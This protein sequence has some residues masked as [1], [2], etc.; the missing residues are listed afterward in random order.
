MNRIGLLTSGGDSPGMNP[1]IR[2]VIH[3]AEQQGVE[4]V[5][6]RRGFAGLL[7][8][9]CFAMTSK[10]VSGI[11]Q[12]GGTVLLTARCEDF[13]YEEGQKEGI[14]NLIKNKCDGL[15]VIGGDGSF[16]GAQAISDRGVE[17]IGVP[18]TIDNDIYGTD[19]ALGTDTSMNNIIDVIDKIKDTASSHERTFII[20][21]MGR[22]SGYLALMSGIATGAEAVLIPEVKYDLDK[23]A[24]RIKLRYSQGKISNILIVAEGT[25]TGYHIGR[26]LSKIANI[27][28]K[29]TVLGHLQRGGSPSGFDRVLGSR[30]GSAAV[31][32]LL[33]GN[34]N[35][36]VGLVK[37]KA[38]ITQFE[39]V[40]SHKREL[41][42]TL[43]K[44]A[45]VL[46]K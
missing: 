27:V 32:K 26:Q 19:M 31:L 29:I 21:T 16:K 46:G 28:S 11:I 20:E 22:G 6:F 38:T 43:I 41:G 14:A 15:I 8:N 9:D 25:A 39:T 4:V 2:A 24:Q 36:M 40:F 3:E 13:K 42:P 35:C 1:C 12:K 10:D 44:L 17:V 23:I 45:E 7:D 34:S 37:G 5:A 30:L 33:E 18:A